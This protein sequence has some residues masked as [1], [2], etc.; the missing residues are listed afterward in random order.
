MHKGEH[1]ATL[2]ALR[3]DIHWAVS[4]AEVDAGSGALAA[5]MCRSKCRPLP[6]FSDHPPIPTTSL[7]GPVRSISSSLAQGE[8]FLGSGTTRRNVK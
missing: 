2:S 5:H 8:S 1:R 7:T 6:S 4:E 3:R